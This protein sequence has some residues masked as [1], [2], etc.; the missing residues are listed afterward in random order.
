MPRL[1]DHL[2]AV[3]PSGIRRLFEIAL[4]LEGVTF[5]CVGEPDVPTAPHIIEA[6]RA[7]WAADDTNYGPN[8]GIPELRRAI[9]EKLARDNGIRADVEQVW[10]TVGGTQALYQAMTLTLRTGDEVLVPDPGYTTFTMNARMI[11]A[12][13]VPYTLRPENGFLPDLDELERIVTDRTRVIIV[14]SPSNP[15]GIV[16]PRPVLERL[17]EFARR[18]DLW[19]ISDEVYE[20]FTYGRPHTSL[21]SIAQEL[22]HDDDRVFS[23]FSFSKTYAM[24]GV[25]VGYL[26]TPPGMTTTMVTVQE[27]AISCV[28]SPDQRAALAALTGPQEAVADAAAHYL[29]NLRLATSILDERGIRYRE[30]E[31][32]FYLWIDLSH[33]T[34][35]DVA[36]WVEAF[37]LETLVAVAP[38]SA[39]GR[40]GEGWIR[41]CLAADPADIEHGLRTLPAPARP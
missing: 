8:G 3:P 23:V 28:A 2:P 37:L 14:N 12:V 27:A 33:A 7:A 15:L 17:L 39:F 18:H 35:G 25:R 13:P 19:I 5:L 9:V 20:Y 16:F 34:G 38:G 10:L 41:I 24:T 21:A 31:G 36:S 40:T 29:A 26:V 4:R 22:G 30:P 6:A 32:A 11:E 1:A